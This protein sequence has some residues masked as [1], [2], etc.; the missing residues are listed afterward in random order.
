MLSI[1]LPQLLHYFP[2]ETCPRREARAACLRWVRVVAGCGL[3]LNLDT[4][5]KAPVRTTMIPRTTMI[6]VVFGEPVLPLLLNDGL[7]SALV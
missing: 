5:I 6:V 7:E 2:L 3:D 1:V 4:T